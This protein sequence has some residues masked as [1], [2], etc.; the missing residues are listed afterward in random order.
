M[1]KDK[2]KQLFP[3][4]FLWGASV[5]SHQVEGNN[6]NQ[7]T[8]WELEN[9]TRLAKSAKQRLDW[10]PKWK[11]IQ[12]QAE[13]PE[14]YISGNAVDH[15]RKYKEDL[16]L[17]KSLNINSFRFGVEWSRVEPEEGPWD[18]PS[19]HK[20]WTVPVHPGFYRPPQRS[21]WCRSQR[22]R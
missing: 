12:S 19:C 8:V 9:A 4:N 22:R 17:A 5:A 2:Q 13:D 1:A 11:D 20:A 21:S 3:K 16:K 18:D 6:E 7:W 15:Y 14:N 10:M